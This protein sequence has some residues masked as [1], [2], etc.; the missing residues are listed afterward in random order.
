MKKFELN[1]KSVALNILYVP[2][3]PEKIRHVFKSKYNK[4]RENQLNLLIITDGK[5]WNYLAVK[6]LSALSHIVYKIYSKS[7][8]MYAKIIIIVM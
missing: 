6:G 8:K 7:M 2:Y 5:K 1:N 3:N 4:E